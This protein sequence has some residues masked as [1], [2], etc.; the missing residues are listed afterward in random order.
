MPKGVTS[1]IPKTLCVPLSAILT[2]VPMSPQTMKFHP[3]CPVRRSLRSPPLHL[4]H[5]M[6]SQ[7]KTSTIPLSIFAR[8]NNFS[9]LMRKLT[10]TLQLSTWVSIV[11]IVDSD[12]LDEGQKNQVKFNWSS[13]K[14]TANSRHFK[15]SHLLA[16]VWSSKGLQVSYGRNLASWKQKEKQW[17]SSTCIR[18]RT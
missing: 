18:V 15:A 17:Q 14:G 7:M 3:G 16:L 5:K 10:S 1:H 13:L 11:D 4:R 2:E 6:N 8:R 12:S 9:F